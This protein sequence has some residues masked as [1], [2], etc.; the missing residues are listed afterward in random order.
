M[1]PLNYVFA[2]FAFVEV[3]GTKVFEELAGFEV[4]SEL[5]IPLT[6]WEVI[7]YADT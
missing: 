3:S 2:T 4:D 7:F 6:V 5:L 1:R